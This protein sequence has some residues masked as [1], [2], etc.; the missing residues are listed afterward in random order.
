MRKKNGFDSL[1][2]G[3]VSRKTALRRADDAFSLYIRTRD[4]QR[5]QCKMFRC[6]SCGRL[7]PIQQCDCGH[8][9]N[10]SHHSL[11]FSEMNCNGQ[12]RHCNR[13]DE[14]NIQGYRA[15]LVQRYGENR[16]RILESKRN[17][18]YPLTAF[19]LLQIEKEYIMKEQQLEFHIK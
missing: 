4:S 11:R 18:R 19:I 15:G 13:F 16:V 5:W 9:I 8:Y 3:E 17:E 7:L 12:C 10:R 14:G 6:I 2:R 1:E